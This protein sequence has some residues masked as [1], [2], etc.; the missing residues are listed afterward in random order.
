MIISR[1]TMDHQ[2]SALLNSISI[3]TKF[4]SCL[5]AGAAQMLVLRDVPSIRRTSSQ[6]VSDWLMIRHNAAAQ[7]MRGEYHWPQVWQSLRGCVA[8]TGSCWNIWLH[9]GNLILNMKIILV[10][11]IHQL[12]S[13]RHMIT[14]TALTALSTMH[15]PVKSENFMKIFSYQRQSSW[16]TTQIH[17]EYSQKDSFT[18]DIGICTRC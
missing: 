18:D 12:Q 2:N 1:I 6:L 5:Y 10:T 13:L 14:L 17:I 16:S 15:L 4:K 11:C 9:L 3:N 7:P 8:C